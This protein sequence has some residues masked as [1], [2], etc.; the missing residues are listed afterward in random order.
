MFAP[1]CRACGN[2]IMDGFMSAM[3]TQWHPECFVCKVRIFITSS[4]FELYLMLRIY[5][6]RCVTFR[7][8]VETYSS[9]RAGRIASSTTMQQEGHFVPAVSSQ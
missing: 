2:A 3:G 7:S 1:R 6:V 8:K 5:F 4:V 9:W